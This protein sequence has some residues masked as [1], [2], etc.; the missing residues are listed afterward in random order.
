MSRYQ[1]LLVISVVL[2]RYRPLP[3]ISVFCVG[4]Y[5]TLPVISSLVEIQVTPCH[6]TICHQNITP[7]DS[8]GQSKKKDVI[9]EIY[10]TRIMDK[11]IKK[12]TNKCVKEK[13]EKQGPHITSYI[14]NALPSLL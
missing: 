4:K 3:V 8:P 14:T 1:I 11:Q 6:L 10:K 13:T 7:L 12:S 5:K 9:N 2:R